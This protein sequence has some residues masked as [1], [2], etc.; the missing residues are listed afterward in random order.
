M[1]RKCRE[2]RGLNGTSPV[3]QEYTRRSLRTSWTANSFPGL[4]DPDHF[5]LLLRQLQTGNKVR[6]QMGT[7]CLHEAKCLQYLCNGADEVGLTL[8]HNQ[9]FISSFCAIILSAWRPYCFF[10]SFS[11][12]LNCTDF[13]LFWK[14]TSDFL[15]YKAK[16]N[17]TSKFRLDIFS[18][19]CFTWFIV[20]PLNNG[21]VPDSSL[22]IQT[23]LCPYCTH[24]SL[25]LLKFPWDP[26]ER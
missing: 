2:T 7:F 24:Y 12:C 3:G 23:L 5:P 1:Q 9:I 25:K 21:L 14:S 11:C 6:K 26:K 16:N 20:Q 8:G 13:S 15:F 10:S 19:H 22:Q 17:F 4:L 18:G